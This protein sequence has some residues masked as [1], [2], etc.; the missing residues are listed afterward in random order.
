MEK[1]ITWIVEQVKTEHLQEVMN[2]FDA[3][4][5]DVDTYEHLIESY[6]SVL[7]IVVGKLKKSPRKPRSK[8]PKVAD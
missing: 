3:N 6:E 5:Y 1:K 2:K 4:G 7:W 8:K